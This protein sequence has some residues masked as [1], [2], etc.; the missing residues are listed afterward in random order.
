MLGLLA[1]LAADAQNC[2]PTPD[3]SFA[4]TT[5]A[6]TYPHV[7]DIGASPTVVTGPR[8]GIDQTHENAY[9][10]Q[11][12]CPLYAAFGQLL[13]ADGATVVPFATPFV[14]PNPL[15][16]NP[17]YQ[18][19]LNQLDILVIVEPGPSW[20]PQ[21]AIGYA[22]A[23]W[24][25]KWVRGEVGCDN[26]CEGRGLIL[27]SSRPQP[28]LTTHFGVTWS[29]PTDVAREFTLCGDP[30]VVA[31]A[32]YKKGTLKGDHVCAQ[33]LD[34]SEAVTS[35]KT[36]MHGLIFCVAD[37]CNYQMSV[38]KYANATIDLPTGNPSTSLLTLP[39]GTH[40]AG[41]AFQLGAGRVYAGSDPDMFTAVIAEHM[42]NVIGGFPAVTPPIP[43][44]MQVHPPNQHYLLNVIH[45][46]DGILPDAD[47]D[48]LT[49]GRDMCRWEP[50]A[51][52]PYTN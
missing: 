33:G 5:G 14:G 20:A 30:R 39:D 19:A 24:L 22:E 16:P 27:I 1:P 37:D 29:N 25:R 8:I 3:P 49:D 4:P 36:F 42:V 26:G 43:M 40:S 31:D 32:V 47:G 45:W 44:G 6:P 35:V 48:G 17:Q 52:W 21:A 2:F 7:T 38:S 23:N 50:P 10:L 34:S 12:A 9:S 46:I 13:T 15:L 11:A 41:V 51:V 28:Q 18:A